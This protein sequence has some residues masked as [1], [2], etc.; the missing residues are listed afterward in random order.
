MFAAPDQEAIVPDFVN[1]LPLHPLVVHAVV[2]LLPLACLGVIAIALRTSWR[3]RYAGLVV[4]VAAA[5][6]AAIPVATKSGESLERRVGNP[7]QHAELGDSLL[8]F[9]L[10]L[11]AVAAALFVLHRLAA[12]DEAPAAQVP[13]AAHIPRAAHVPGAAH[14]PR[15]AQVPAAAGRSPLMLAVA[16]LAVVI[17]AANL[18]QIYRVGDSGA[19]AVWQGTQSTPAQDR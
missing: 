14:V 8:W 6:T 7:G 18:V 9:A 3:A 5:A 19:R 2:V 1:G 10:P 17:A 11:L 16:A 15:A 4:A 12:R 13:G